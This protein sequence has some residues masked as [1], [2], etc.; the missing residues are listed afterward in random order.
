MTYMTFQ[1]RQWL[2]DTSEVQDMP[3]GML[4]KMEGAF[5]FYLC[6]DVYLGAG[7]IIDAGAFLGASAFCMAKGLERNDRITHKSGRLHSYD[8]FRVWQEEGESVEYMS[9]QLKKHFGISVADDE[10][11]FHVF[12]RNLGEYSRHIRIYPGD[13]TQTKWSGRP[14]EILFNDVSKTLPIWRHVLRQFFP[15]LMP[16]ISLVI[17]QDYHHPLLPWIHVVQEYLSPFFEVAESHVQDSA[18]FRLVERIPDRVLERISNYDFTLKDEIGMLD[19]AIKRLG[20]D[21]GHVAL[22][23]AVLLGRSRRYDEAKEILDAIKGL[24]PT[25]KDTKLNFSLFLA[26]KAV[27]R[28]EALHSALPA[29]FDERRYLEA[30]S[31]VAKAVQSGVFD[32]GYHHWLISGKYEG[33]SMGKSD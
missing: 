23:K 12:F 2:H 14:I 32:S 11:T 18:V 16:G 6:R 7:E 1:N 5:L 29:G 17:Q 4:S 9:D 26:S 15:S 27:T 31:D 3:H 13:I 25:T 8:L 33:R 22:A 24:L 28:E 21:S 10:S 30:H 19:T 20:D